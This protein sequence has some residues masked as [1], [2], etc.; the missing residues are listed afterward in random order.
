MT[1]AATL[2]GSNMHAIQRFLTLL[3][4][5]DVQEDLAINSDGPGGEKYQER[6]DRVINMLKRKCDGPRQDGK[7]HG[8]ILCVTNADK[9]AL[10]NPYWLKIVA[11]AAEK[12][13][14]GTETESFILPQEIIDKCL[15]WR[16]ETVD[17]HLATGDAL[18]ITAG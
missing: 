8:Q 11:I 10:E 2:T 1:A 3:W 15:A 13:W 12:H 6:L 4:Y 16:H 18:R 9:V 17:I 14:R 7:E 5:P